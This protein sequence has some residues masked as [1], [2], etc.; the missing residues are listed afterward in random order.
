MQKVKIKTPTIRL[1]QFMKWASITGS[2]GE[3]KYLITEGQ[4]KVNGE[5][6]IRRGKTLVAGDVVEFDGNNYQV[7]AGE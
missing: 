4:V 7:E 1:D 3:A 6:E 2:G 5:Q